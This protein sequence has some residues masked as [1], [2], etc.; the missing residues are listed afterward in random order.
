[1]HEREI[2]M[3]TNE[4]KIEAY[5]YILDNQEKNCMIEIIRQHISK[6]LPLET[7]I[8]HAAEILNAERNLSIA[9]Q[10]LWDEVSFRM[11]ETQIA[12]I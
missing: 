10:N 7:G 9:H 12:K 11:K 6:V 5:K 3:I 4:D 1:M 2:K 8:Y